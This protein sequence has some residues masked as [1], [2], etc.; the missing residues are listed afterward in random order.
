MKKDKK[1]KTA[2]PWKPQ[3]SENGLIGW[4][5]HSKVHYLKHDL[6]REKDGFSFDCDVI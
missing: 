4:N 3:I 6:E 2:I 5:Q 1:S